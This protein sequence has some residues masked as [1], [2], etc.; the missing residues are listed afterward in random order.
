LE[1]WQ[2]MEGEF[3]V[4]AENS[5]EPG[6]RTPDLELLV[7]EHWAP[8]YRTVLSIVR[9]HGVAEDVTQEV[10]LKAW[11]ALPGFRGEAS[12]RNWILRIAHNSAISYLRKRRPE[13]YEPW[14][15]PER[16]LGRD[17]ADEAVNRVALDRV[18]EALAELS[19]STR[20]IVVL[21]EVESRS[22]E[23]IAR[24]VRLPLPTVRTRLF[25]ARKQLAQALKEWK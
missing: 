23:D 21:R 13:L 4:S 17:V 1:Q 7:R 2:V 15:L 9:D 22:Y 10:L 16:E 12:L 5:T 20:S 25:R 18:A 6:A 8:V 3:T 14:N 11:R 24:I 19:P